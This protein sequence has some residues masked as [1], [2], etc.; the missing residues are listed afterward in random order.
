MSLASN[1][2]EPE[3]IVA[4]ATPQGVGALGIVRISGPHAIPIAASLIALNHSCPLE[5]LPSQKSALGTFHQNGTKID[6]VMVTLFRAPKS[7]TGEDLVEISAH[8]SPAVL[9]RIVQL[10]IQG[11]V[12]LA[13]PGEF[14]QRAFLNGKLD[15]AQAEA[16]A[17]LIHAQTEFARASALSQLE[18]R[19]SSEVQEIKGS[20]IEI[21]AHI[22]IEI[23]HSDD[24]TVGR[25]MSVSEIK[26][27][28]KRALQKTEKLIQ[29]YEFGRILR[30]GIKIAIIGKPNAGKSSLL[31]TLLRS[32]RAIVTSAPGTTRDTI[33]ETFNLLGIQ[34]ILVDTAGI[35]EKVTDLTEQIGIERTAKAIEESDIALAVMDNSIPFSAEDEQVARLLS[36]KK[37]VVIAINKSDLPEKLDR[38]NLEKNFPNFPTVSISALKNEGIENLLQILFKSATGEGELKKQAQETL[39]TSLR[40]RNC[41]AECKLHLDRAL[42]QSD[43]GIML[44]CLAQDLRQGVD[45]LG[46]IIGEVYTEEILKEIFSKFCIGK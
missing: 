41:L 45:A 33:E 17:E 19:L 43:K 2:L 14:S 5:S 29:S 36:S 46:E 15:L 27:R 1:P 32:E 28:L 44:E 26:K 24:P 38:K 22:E 13:E 11:G 25:T 35:R 34:A 23:D 39:I 31:N 30:E 21:L 37:T 42:A 10:L 20:L 4:I 18:G 3:T 8:G 16:V 6:Q 40:H 7:F 9:K 12:R